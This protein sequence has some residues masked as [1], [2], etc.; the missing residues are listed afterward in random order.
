MSCD[1]P[2]DNR[3]CWN[4]DPEWVSPCRHLYRCA[5][6]FKQLP[7]RIYC[8]HCAD[9]IPILIEEW[10]KVSTL[11]TVK[12]YASTTINYSIGL[13]GDAFSS[14]LSSLPEFPVSLGAVEYTLDCVSSAI[15]KTFVDPPVEWE[16][17]LF[18]ADEKA[19]EPSENRCEEDSDFEVLELPEGKN[20]NGDLSDDNESD[21]WNEIDSAH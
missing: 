11:T 15:P 9:R 6:C 4:N 2:I 17:E 13:S 18:E 20:T 19:G 10:E 21:G 16:E 1:A 12:D 8:D 7:K 3:W 5:A 14:L